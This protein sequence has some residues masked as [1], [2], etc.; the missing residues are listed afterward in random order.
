MTM[1]ITAA[2][3]RVHKQPL[4]IEALQLECETGSIPLRY[5][6]SLGM[7]EPSDP[8]HPPRLFQTPSNSRTGRAGGDERIGLPPSVQIGYRLEPALA[9]C[10]SDSRDGGAE[11]HRHRAADGSY[12]AGQE[13]STKRTVERL[14]P[15]R[16]ILNQ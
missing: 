5:L 11:R 6:R 4:R 8:A 12:D 15:I 14:T 2:V 16:G 10:P 13:P 1:T 7:R 3:A 9:A